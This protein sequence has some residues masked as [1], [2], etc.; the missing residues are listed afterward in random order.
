[1]NNDTRGLLFVAAVAGGF[2]FVAPS[3]LP[4]QKQSAPAAKSQPAPKVQPVQKT[5]TPSQRTTPTPRPRPAISRPERKA[6]KKQTAAPK[7]KRGPTASQCADLRDGI[8]RHGITIVR[9]GARLRGYS[10]E[11]FNWAHQRCGL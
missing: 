11:D 4:V 2:V 5:S 8:D 6:V 7:Q 10:T 1:M 9:A 3:T